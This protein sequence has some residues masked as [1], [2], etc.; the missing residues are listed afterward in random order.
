[1]ADETRRIMRLGLKMFISGL[2]I[3]E[4]HAILQ[5]RSSNKENTCKC[6]GI[7]LVGRRID[8]EQAD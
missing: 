4:G 1:M 2:E 3:R 5:T 6:V 7:M 8:R